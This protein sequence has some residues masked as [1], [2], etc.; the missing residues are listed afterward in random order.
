MKNYLLMIISAL[1]FHKWQQTLAQ[2]VEMKI[3]RYVGFLFK[4]RGES[5]LHIFCDASQKAYAATVFLRVQLDTKISVQLL[6]AK[7]RVAPIKKTTI[8]RLELLA[9]TMAARLGTS[10][11]MAFEED[12][13]CYYW[14]DSSTA[15]A[16]IQREN[17][18]GTFVGNRIKEI[19]SLKNV[20]DIRPW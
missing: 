7:A 10:V 8:P 6:Q 18:L 13:T 17:I 3:P 2:F 4:E 11:K 5:Q 12:V 20:L 16:W 19:N 14:T 15:L 1:I 9:C